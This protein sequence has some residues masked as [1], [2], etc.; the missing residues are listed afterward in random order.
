[1]QKKKEKKKDSLID[2]E[3]EIKLDELSNVLTT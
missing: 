2:E 3:N 1:M